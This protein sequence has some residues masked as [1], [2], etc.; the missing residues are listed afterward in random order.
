MSCIKSIHRGTDTNCGVTTNSADIIISEVDPNKAFVI[1]SYRTTDDRVKL[2]GQLTSATVLT[3]S[4]SAYGVTNVVV[5]NW[6]VIE[7]V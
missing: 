5:T 6:Q 4:S 3:L 7:F 1:I 2:T